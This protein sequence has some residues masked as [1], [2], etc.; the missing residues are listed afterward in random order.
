[1]PKCGRFRHS[2]GHGPEQ[3][4]LDPRFLLLSILRLPPS[5][6]WERETLT[7]KLIP[8]KYVSKCSDQR[9]AILAGK[10]SHLS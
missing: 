7:P 1:M 10:I 5:R 3:F 6:P 8:F 9:F 2:E 4:H